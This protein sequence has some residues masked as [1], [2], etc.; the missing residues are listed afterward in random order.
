MRVSKAWHDV[1]RDEFYWRR[2]TL[3]KPTYDM[4]KFNSFI[5]NYPNIQELTIKDITRFPMPP[6]LF[7]QILSEMSLESLSITCPGNTPRQ[8]GVQR[9]WIYP[10][11]LYTLKKLYLAYLGQGT[12]PMAGW[13]LHQTRPRLEELTIVGLA[14]YTGLLNPLPDAG[15]RWHRLKV[16]RLKLPPTEEPTEINMVSR[17]VCSPMPAVSFAN[18]WTC[19]GGTRRQNSALRAAVSRRLET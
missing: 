5:R 18:L 9:P 2:V 7:R 19:A 4:V 8:K 17:E 11:P 12:T 15:D 14:A 6:K 1:L 10:S 16:L 13:L 3:T